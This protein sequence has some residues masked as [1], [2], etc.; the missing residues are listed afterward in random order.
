MQLIYGELIPGSSLERAGRRQGS[1]KNNTH[2]PLIDSCC[3]QFGLN[4]TRNPLKKMKTRCAS[5]F[6][7]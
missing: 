4:P 6:S 2:E 7:L 1:R 3:G 5:E